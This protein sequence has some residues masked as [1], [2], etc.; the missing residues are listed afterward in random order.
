MGC[1]ENRDVITTDGRNIG[2]LTGAWMDLSNWSVTALI[3][4]L[5]KQVVDELNVKKPM[6]RTARVNIP[7][8]YVKNIADVVQLSA[9]MPTLSTAL[10]TNPV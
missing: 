9:D 5:N 8:N 3:V 7:V 10:A 1:I 2:T 4:E 6:L